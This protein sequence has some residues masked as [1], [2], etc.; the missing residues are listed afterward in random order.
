MG[1]RWQAAIAGAMAGA[2]VAALLGLPVESLA[3]FAA[4]AVCG[5]VALLALTALAQRR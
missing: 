3:P 5:A 1:W 2:G 4:A